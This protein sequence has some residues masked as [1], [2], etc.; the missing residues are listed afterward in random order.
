MN[1]CELEEILELIQDN[2]TEVYVEGTY[3]LKYKIKDFR[4]EKTTNTEQLYLITE[5]SP[6]LNVSNHEI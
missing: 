5:E 1:A 4:F 6:I 2:S 3:G